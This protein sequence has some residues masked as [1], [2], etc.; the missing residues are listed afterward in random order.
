MHYRK[1]SMALFFSLVGSLIA[2]IAA[3]NWVLREWHF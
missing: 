3:S 2:V 1:H